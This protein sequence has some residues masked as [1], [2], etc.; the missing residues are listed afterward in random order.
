MAKQ[1]NAHRTHGR[2]ILEVKRALVCGSC[3]S[4][5]RAQKKKSSAGLHLLVV[6]GSVA[7]AVTCKNFSDESCKSIRARCC[8][9]VFPCLT[10]TSSGNLYGHVV[11]SQ[12]MHPDTDHCACTLASLQFF[13][14]SF[15]KFYR[16]E[17]KRKACRC[18]PQRNTQL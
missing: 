8:R 2:R 17:I 10:A 13:F 18:F 9:L 12:A 1:I 6:S 7:R 15:C 16:G 14:I 5:A 4:K 11:V 3:R